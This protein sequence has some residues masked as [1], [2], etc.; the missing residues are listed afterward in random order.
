MTG[1]RGGGPWGVGSERGDGVDWVTGE[2]EE[3]EK[4]WLERTEELIEG[5]TRGPCGPKNNQVDLC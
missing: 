1:P 3:K 5:S 4:N 2:E